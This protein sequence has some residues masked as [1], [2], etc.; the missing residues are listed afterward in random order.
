MKK[1]ITHI[2][3]LQTAK[4]FALLYFIIT[5]PFAALMALCFSMSPA[6][7]HFP[8]A[9]I[10]IAPFA[11]A[12][13]GFIFTVFGAWVYNLVARWVGGIEFTTAEV[14][15]PSSNHDSVS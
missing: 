13:L 3:P 11:Y 6:S 5:L 7:S 9:M 1:Q 10:F 12:I 2:S 4:V 15:G 14:D 8:V